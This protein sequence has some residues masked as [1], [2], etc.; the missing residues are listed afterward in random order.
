VDNLT[1]LPSREAHVVWAL[2]LLGT[3]GAGTV[4]S[5]GAAVPGEETRPA[6]GI[7]LAEAVAAALDRNFSILA[8]TDS[9]AAAKL[10]E[11]ASRSEFSPTLTPQYVRSSD[12]QALALDATQKLPWSGGR[13]SATAAFRS[14]AGAEVA[15]T[16]FSDMRLLFTQP[17]LRG[18][19][20]TATQFE[21]V[22]SQRARQTQERSLELNRQRL[23]VQVA[24]VFY[25]IVQQRQLLAVAE[26]SLKRSDGLRRASEARLEVGL[27]SKLD[28]FRAQLAASQAEEARIR[29]QA[30]LEDALERFRVLLGLAPTDATEPEAVALPDPSDGA[31]EPVEVLVARALANR[32]ELEETR[33]QVGD[34][35]RAVSLTR[36]NLLPQVDLNLALTR[37]GYGATV[38]DTFRGVDRG[39]TFFLTT[40]YPLA[41]GNAVAA[42]ATAELEVA[43]RA[44]ALE[45][46]RR[47]I[48]SEVRGAA[49]EMER[50]R[51]SVD[52]QGQA[53]EVAE[54]QLR[55]ATLRYQRGLA[56]NFDV[57]D[58]EGSLIQARTALVGL[59]AGYQVARIELLRVTGT[60]DL[61]REFAP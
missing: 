43:A 7:S 2:I 22:N 18:F 9:V 61:A 50:I 14:N 44:R 20:P 17:L 53:V 58:A 27:A 26:Q 3:V 8:A 54:Q 42:K 40:S 6:A 5:E 23:A 11:T 10:R 29:A 28:V 16:R 47:E 33:D 15:P 35:R 48:E 49:R 55:L 46:R 60:L 41:R 57:V 32:V 56:N 19:G 25:Q 21:L 24:A 34:A 4:V 1:L 38:A 30:G 31:L 12:A 51:K 52:L 37:G 13:L 45:Q 39:F 59:L 36:Q